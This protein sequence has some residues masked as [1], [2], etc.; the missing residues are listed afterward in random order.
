MYG[1]I[2]S[3]CVDGVDGVVLLFHQPAPSA[4][5]HRPLCYWSADL[6]L[7]K[8]KAIGRDY[9]QHIGPIHP[10]QIQRRRWRRWRRRRRRHRF[11]S[12]QFQCITAMYTSKKRHLIISFISNCPPFNLHPFIPS[13]S[14]NEFKLRQ[15]WSIFDKSEIWT[16][17]KMLFSTTLMYRSLIVII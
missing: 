16:L 8:G 13:T 17:L 11:G 6:T 2:V 1:S 12:A 4:H 10:P 7:V 14:S 9:R 5:L 3:F 15:I